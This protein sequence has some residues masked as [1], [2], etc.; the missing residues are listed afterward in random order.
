MVYVISHQTSTVQ[1]E[2]STCIIVAKHK[3]QMKPWN[4]NLHISHFLL[5]PIRSVRLHEDRTAGL[6]TWPLALLGF[7]TGAQMGHIK[8]QHVEPC[9]VLLMCLVRFVFVAGMTGPATRKGSKCRCL[10]FYK[11][12]V[13]TFCIWVY[14]SIKWNRI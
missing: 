7:L 12:K 10:I 8:H 2:T 5:S 9:P 3:L 1:H 11:S 13:S 6:H 4:K 14:S